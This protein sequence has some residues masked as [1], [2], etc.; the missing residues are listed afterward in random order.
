VLVRHAGLSQNSTRGT[1]AARIAVR[2]KMNEKQLESLMRSCEDII[3]GAPTNAK[4]TL[5][6]V[7]QLRQIEASLG[8]Q[9]RARDTR[10]TE[11]A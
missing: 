4:E 6:L 8:L 7:R 11:Q 5:R 10:Q 1:I 2:S 3:N 9:G